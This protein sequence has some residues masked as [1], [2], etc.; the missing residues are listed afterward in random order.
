MRGIMSWRVAA[1]VVLAA[2]NSTPA[3]VT[4]AP[5][6]TGSCG[7]PSGV[8]SLKVTAFGPGG[9]VT[10]AVAPDAPM[11]IG[12]FPAGTMQLAVDVL[13]AN[14]EVG[15]AGKTAPLAFDDLADGATIPIFMAPLDGFCA[16]GPGGR[17]GA[18]VAR[19]GDTVLI[20]GGTAGGLP[21]ATA[22]LYDPATAEFAPIDVPDALRDATEGLAGVVLAPLADGRVVLTGGV[23]GVLTVFD[24]KLRAFGP[25]LVVN[26]RAF[27]AAT[28]IGNTVLVSGG[29]AN[30]VG[31]TCD[32]TPLRSSL[33]YAL[34]GTQTGAPNLPPSSVTE[35]GRLF[36]LGTDTDGIERFAIAGGFGDANAGA[37]FA[38]D[39]A[40]AT[41]LAGLG[42]QAVLLD[43]GA[44]LTAFAP[45]AGAA[46]P[47]V[48]IVAPDGGAVVP[49][50]A[51]PSLA[52]AR[53]VALED[54]SAVAI[55]GDPGGK[56]ARYMP[57]SDHWDVGFPDP[58]G[59]VPG[60][61]DAPTLVRLADGSVLVLA[62]TGA[63]VYRPSLVGPATGSLTILPASA[64]SSGVLAAP[65]P[66][67][68]SHA[69]GYVLTSADDRL[70]AR[71]LVGGPRLAHGTIA[72]T[73]HDVVGGLALIA[74]Q[75]GPGHAVVLELVPGEPAALIQLAGATT[76]CTGATPIEL[77]AGPV[78]ASLEIRDGTVRAS[79]GGLGVLACSVSLDEIG[80][81]GIASIGS[82]AHLAV[83]AVTVAR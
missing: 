31:G 48:A 75:Q 11:T 66:S 23:R 53:L 4:L 13:V 47:T 70:R 22:E 28:A 32:P 39:D 64:P 5:V 56:I 19:A 54:G 71:A 80:A 50:G 65:D 69:I 33:I 57:T 44:L 72:A 29:C 36:D 30:V 1:W 68:L 14:G 76:L 35:G 51:G 82:A 67:T 46:S 42:G 58:T 45:D 77:P 9:E 21:L 16:V 6:G 12:D 41:P 34:D 49:L 81:W 37:R 78:S 3:H 20:V 8:T 43:G 74:Q 25:V 73:T 24:P 7:R 10:R 40:V 18:V 15:A 55:G 79:V 62:A 59:D 27:H 17:T 26:R 52:G 60:A 2:C 83:D 38:L 61:L 63:W